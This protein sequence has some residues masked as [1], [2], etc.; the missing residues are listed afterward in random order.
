[1]IGNSS[2]LELPFGNPL[3]WVP[4]A[5]GNSFDCN[6]GFLLINRNFTVNVFKDYRGGHAQLFF[7]SSIAFLLLE[8]STSASQSRNLL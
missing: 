7:E 2:K 8:E 3:S 4:A 1:V 6:S 5:F